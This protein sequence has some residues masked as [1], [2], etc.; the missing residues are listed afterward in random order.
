MCGGIDDSAV[1]VACITKKYMNKIGGAN[2]RDNCKLEFGYASRRKTAA[3]ML[4]VVM[5]ACMGD[6]AEWKG[7]LGMVLGGALYSP[8]TRDADFDAQAEKVSRRGTACL[9]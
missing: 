8:L 3:R 4:P 6:P 9:Q 2:E 5:E 7:Q 1:F